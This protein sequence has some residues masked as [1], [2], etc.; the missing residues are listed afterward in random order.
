MWKKIWRE[1][2]RGLM[3]ALIQ[4]LVLG[5]LASFITAKW[6]DNR[7]RA[8][9]RFSLLRDFNDRSVKVIGCAIAPRANC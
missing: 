8:D 6:E 3:L 9:L 2:N 7:K 4:V 1:L 5:L